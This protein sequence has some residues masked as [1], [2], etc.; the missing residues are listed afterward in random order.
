MRLA[1]HHIGRCEHKGKPPQEPEASQHF[2]RKFRPAAGG[3]P[4]GNP[5]CSEGIEQIDRSGH[6]RQTGVE[7]A[8]KNRA[9]FLRQ[10]FDRVG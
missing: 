8:H 4:P 9:C 7:Q 5:R 10:R 2:R 3:H 1:L 6:R